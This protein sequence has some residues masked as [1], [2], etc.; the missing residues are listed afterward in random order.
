MKT[1]N[2]GWDSSLYLKSLKW[3]ESGPA[4]SRRHFPG[5][6][7]QLRKLHSSSVNDQEG[8]SVKST[9]EAPPASPP[10][11]QRTKWDQDYFYTTRDS[12]SVTPPT[13]CRRQFPGRLPE[14]TEFKVSLHLPAASRLICLIT[15]SLPGSWGVSTMDEGRSPLDESPGYYRA[16]HQSIFTF[17]SLS[18]KVGYCGFGTLLKDS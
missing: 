18:G 15:L 5:P 13:H 4:A 14:G 8:V 1:R 11:V 9:G 16:L 7:A 6:P 10:E 12:W 3:S 17:F 2:D